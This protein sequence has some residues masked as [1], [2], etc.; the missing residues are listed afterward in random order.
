MAVDLA[1]RRSFYS[2][3]SAFSGKNRSSGSNGK[4]ERR[5]ERSQLIPPQA[6]PFVPVIPFVPRSSSWEAFLPD[7]PCDVGVEDGLAVVAELAV[8]LAWLSPTCTCPSRS[9]RS[10]PEI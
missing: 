4:T 6:N 7:A 2:R 5:K 8:H 9:P 3:S 10:G 1:V